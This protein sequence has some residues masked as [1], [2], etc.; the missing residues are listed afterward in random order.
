MCIHD[1]SYIIISQRKRAINSCLNVVPMSSDFV[2][3]WVYARIY[4]MHTCTIHI[5][6]TAAE[7][8]PSFFLHLL[9]PYNF[10]FVRAFLFHHKTTNQIYCACT[11]Q[12]LPHFVAVMLPHSCLHTYTKMKKK[13]EEKKKDIYDWLNA[14]F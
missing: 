2:Y 12:F 10:F 13:K 4:N 1:A 7:R 11:A 6:S 3:C 8:K 9:S 5:A 14:C